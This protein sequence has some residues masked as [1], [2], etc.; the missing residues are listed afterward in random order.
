MAGRATLNATATS[1]SKRKERA[2][3]QMISKKE[4][5]ECQPKKSGVKIEELNV[6][7]HGS[8]NGYLHL[9]ILYMMHML[10]L[11]LRMVTCTL[12][13]SIQ[14]LLFT[15]PFIL[16]G[17]LTTHGIDMVLPILRTTM[18]VTLQVLEL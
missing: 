14:V 11:Q 16:S 13:F 3:R 7:T 8:D 5:K 9:F 6:V 17:F 1:G 4:M 10:Y 15:S 18:H 2:R 12:G